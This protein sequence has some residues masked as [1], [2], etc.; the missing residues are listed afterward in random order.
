MNA[1][2]YD[3]LKELGMFKDSYESPETVKLT[4]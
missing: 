4:T 1:R 2:F 3:F